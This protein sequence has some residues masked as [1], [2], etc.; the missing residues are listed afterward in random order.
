M[1]TLVVGPVVVVV[2]AY[3]DLAICPRP[4]AGDEVDVAIEAD[5]RIPCERP[6]ARADGSCAS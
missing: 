1:S 6:A 4:P 5:E 2:A 3:T